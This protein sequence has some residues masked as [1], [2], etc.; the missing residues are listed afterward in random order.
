MRSKP[1]RSVWSSMKSR[2]FNPN[3]KSYKN[4]GGRGVTVCERWEDFNNFYEDMGERPSDNHSLDRVDNDGDYCPENCRWA[5]SIEQNRNCRSNRLWEHD[6]QT[7]T[8]SMWAEE[9]KISYHTLYKRWMLG[10]EIER[11]LTT[12]PLER[13][14]SNTL[15]Y[16]YEG[17]TH[18]LYKWSKISGINRRTLRTRVVDQGWSIKDAL[19]T[20][21]KDTTRQS[22]KPLFLTYDGRTQRASAW[23][24]EAGMSLDNLRARIGLGWSVEKAIK[25]PVR[26]Y[27]KK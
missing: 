17:K 19:N 6:G 26:E 9:L 3:E 24:K 18:T 7:M 5:T 1:E 15:E 22:P 8:I 12:P 11:I 13:T 14:K 21:V 10:W 25:T 27:K 4:Y 23:A 20:P 16:T 2:C